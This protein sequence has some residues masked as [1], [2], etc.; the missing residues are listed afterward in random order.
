LV[1]TGRQIAWNTASQV[2]ARLA[3]MGIAL[4]T[5][6]LVTRYLGV[7][8][9]GDL[10]AITVYV[11]VFGVFFDL[12]ISTIVLR[13]LAQRIASPEELIGKVLT[14]RLGLATVVALVAGL[15]A[16]TIYG[17]SE[18]HQLRIGIVIALPV[19]LANAVS[20]TVT[21]FFQ[22]ELKM[23]RLAA[24]EVATQLLALGLI[25]LFVAL[26]EGF[27]AIVAAT[28]AATVFSAAVA[29]LLFR[30]LVP[31]RFG[32]DFT[33][34]RRLFVKALPIGIALILNVI[35]F[36]LDAFLLSLLKGSR[37]VGIYGIAFRFSEMLT[38]FPL[39][40]VAS[41]FPV[42]A[43]TAAARRDDQLWRAT[44]RAF[45]VL[46]LAAVPVVLGTIAIAPQIVHALAGGAFGDAELP[47][48]LIIFG[49]GL[50][51]LTTLF[52]YILVALD[53]QRAGVWLS[54]LTLLVNLGL[55]LALIPPYGYVAA[56]AAASGTDALLLVGLLVIVRHYCG[57][58]PS[59]A[60]AVKAAL[61]GGVMFGVVLAFHPNLPVAVVVG[62]AV[63]GAALYVLGV[64]DQIELRQLLTRRAS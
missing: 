49:T 39:F 59:L 11:S 8:A 29:L 28:A 31:L 1:V 16:F 57:F 45:D 33:L 51:F 56:A 9:Y 2:A 12:G 64:Y 25:G 15:L 35:Y 26:D 18:H 46:L 48:R 22:A 21:A 55:N 61:A 14:L 30:A 62:A 44:Q 23:A 27:Y 24:V 10:V 19:I 37:D 36:R 7:R 20:S 4:A 58:T 41:V 54:S 50:A 17:G 53:R 40:F 3:A 43:A 6:V 60:I 34:W 42:L 47:L 63:Y 52:T 13:Q 38:P 5:L 32:I